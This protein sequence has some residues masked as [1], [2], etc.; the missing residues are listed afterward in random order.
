MRLQIRVNREHL[1][2]ALALLHLMERI[3]EAGAGFRSLTESI[4][5]TTP[6]G[7]MMMQMVGAFAEFEREMIRERPCAG[8]EAARAQGRRGGR[9]RK[10]SLCRG[11]TGAHTAD[12]GA[13]KSIRHVS[14]RP[15][16]AARAGLASKGILP[17]VTQLS[18][19]RPVGREQVIGAR[20]VR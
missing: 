4:D 17:L 18:G 5:T 6:A 13:R 12:L 15:G 16:R 19:L 1:L 11:P 14:V 20:E 3:T 9:P 8:L 2:H 7:R 10:L